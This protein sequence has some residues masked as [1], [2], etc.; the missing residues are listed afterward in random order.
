MGT[1]D[2][3]A[4]GLL[5]ILV[6]RATKLS[7]LLMADHKTYTGTILFGHIMTHMMLMVQ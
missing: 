1:L 4:S 3:L 6:G 5:I 2:P 7:G